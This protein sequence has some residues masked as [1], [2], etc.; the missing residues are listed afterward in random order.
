MALEDIVINEVIVEEEIQLDYRVGVD[1]EDAFQL[2]LQIPGNE[3]KTFQDYLNWMRK[4]AVDKAA[5]LDIWKAAAIQE[6][7]ESLRVVSYPDIIGPD[8]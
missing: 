3:N 6:I 4:P 7:N 8:Y 1:G 5:E 2:W